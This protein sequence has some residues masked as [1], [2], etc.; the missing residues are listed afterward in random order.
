MNYK[1]HWVYAHYDPDTPTLNS[2]QTLS[3]VTVLAQIGTK[4]KNPIGRDK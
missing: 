3:L 2:D 4:R 1:S